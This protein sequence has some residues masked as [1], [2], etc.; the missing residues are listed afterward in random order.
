MKM[1]TKISGLFV[2]LFLG[3][4]SITLAQ[5]LSNKLD[6]LSYGIGVLMADKYMKEG[7]DQLNEAQVAAGLR[8]ALAKNDQVLSKKESIKIYRQILKERKAMVHERTKAAGEA[9]LAENA[10]KVSVLTTESGLQYEVIATGTGAK[11]GPTDKVK[12]HYHGMLIDGTVFDSSVERN[13][14]LDLPVNGVIQG[15]QEALQMMSEGD[16]WRLT[17]PY[18]L[19]YGANGAGGAIPPYAALIFDVE[20]IKIL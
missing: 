15:W 13:K 19:A 10:K 12:V 14:P 2:A 1:N 16:K 11:P 3:L 18:N 8:D 20:L 6:S 4:S 9:Y 7:I 5:T 17:I